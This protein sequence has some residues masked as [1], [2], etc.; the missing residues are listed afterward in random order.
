MHLLYG[1]KQWPRIWALRL[2]SVL[3]DLGFERTDCD[4]SVYVYQRGDVRILLPIHVDDLLLASNSETAIADVKSQLASHFKLHDQGPATSILGMKIERNRAARTISLSQ[5]GYIES[6]LDAFSMSNCNPARTPMEENLK[7]SAKMSPTTPEGR[8]AMKGTP[9]RELIGKLLYLSVATRPDISYALGV[10][11]R[12]VENAGTEH[13]N[14]A[15]R[16]L[17]YLAGTIYLVRRRS[18]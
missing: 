5:P 4:Y 12:F 13:W 6:I 11:C 9:Y 2:H 15:K 18:Q 8:L 14:A 17:R 16:V 1:I 3:T 7:F 10:L